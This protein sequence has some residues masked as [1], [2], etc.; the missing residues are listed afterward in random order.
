MSPFCPDEKKYAVVDSV[1]AYYQDKFDKSEKVMGQSITSI[2]TVNGVR[3]TLADGTWGLIRAS[4][5]K[6]SLVVVVESPASS[7]QMHAMFDEINSVLG[8]YPDV[9]EYDQ[10]LEKAA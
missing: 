7:A 2:N 1:I 5:N 8:H 3:V 4:S 6:P 10:R 9:G